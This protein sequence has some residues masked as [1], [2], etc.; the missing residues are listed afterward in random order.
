MSNR[1]IILIYLFII[2]TASFRPCFAQLPENGLS[3]CHDKVPLRYGVVKAKDTTSSLSEATL[4]HAGMVFIKGG[5]FA[6][7]S[8]LNEGRADEYPKHRVRV[9]DYW[10]DQT[11]VTNADFKKFVDATGYITTAEKIPDWEELKMQLPAGTPKPDDSV[12]MA[13]SL[14]FTPPLSSVNL[15]DVSGWWQWTK[16]ANWK[17]P[18]GTN[19]TITG[20]ENLPVVHIS[21]DDANAYAKW[22]GKRLP[23]EAEWEYAAR[24]GLNDELFTWGTSEIESG[25][26]KANTWQGQFPYS[27]TVWDGFSKL[28]PVKCYEPNK[29]GLY[30][31]AGNVWEWCADLYNVDYYAQFENALADNPAGPAYSYDPQEPGIAKRVVRGGS[32]LC[33]ASYCSGYRVAA[34][35]KSSPDTGL[36][37]TGFRCVVSD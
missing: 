21:W 20:M 22:A 10:M 2:Q 36:Q 34:R 30:D 17:H 28:A 24:G 23:T 5:V 15:N 13:A 18:E 7:G 3:S 27:N 26:P 12:L 14:V 29:Y 31:M 8:N 25:K 11:E 1:T 35:M 19:S 33:N 37:N 9:S 6:M 32:F 4:S 16:G